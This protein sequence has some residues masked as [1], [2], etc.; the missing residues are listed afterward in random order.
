[1]PPSRGSSQPRIKPKSPTFQAD[2]LLSEPSG[3]PKSPS[4]GDLPDP[5]VLKDD[6]YKS[7]IISFFSIL[8]VQK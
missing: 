8:L 4:P 6:S 2:S 7:M 1:M 3:R 5:G